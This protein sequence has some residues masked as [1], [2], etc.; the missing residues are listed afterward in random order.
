MIRFLFSAFLILFLGA[1]YASDT[2]GDMLSAPA[3]NKYEA[4]VCAA[5]EREPTPEKSRDYLLQFTKKH[6]AGAPLFFNLANVCYRLGDYCAAAKYYKTSL[7]KYKFFAAY[8]NLGFALSAAGDTDAAADALRCAL[9]ISGNSDVPSLMWLADYRA[10]R[11]DYH[12]A[13]ALC[14]Q[15]LIYEPDNDD[16]LYARCLFMSESGDNSAAKRNAEILFDRTSNPR[17]LRVIAKT[18]LA[19]GDTNSAQT[20]L[21]L[22]RKLGLATRAENTLSGD[23]YFALGAYSKAADAYFDGDARPEKL[24]NLALACLNINQS[25]T[26]EKLAKAVKDESARNKILGLSALR[27]G[28]FSAAEKFLQKSVDANPSDAETVFALAET[29]S[30]L[31]KYAASDAAYTRLCAR[32]TDAERALYGLMKNSLAVGNYP[33]ALAYARRLDTENTPPELR[34]FIKKLEKQCNEMEKSSQ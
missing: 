3:M 24:A 27:R 13:A 18:S 33:S 30:Q 6:W 12:A 26:A 8:K 11:G 5:A 28:D 4:E 29:L 31:G 1:S 20:A 23:L 9:A 14:N 10:K 2:V 17:Y 7:E 25:S 15:A 19:L 21:E 22:L 16:L 32:K 34:S